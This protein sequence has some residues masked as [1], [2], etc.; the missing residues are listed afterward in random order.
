MTGSNYVIKP[1]QSRFTWT[2]GDSHAKDLTV[3]HGNKRGSELS[4]KLVFYKQNKFLNAGGNCSVNKIKHTKLRGGFLC[5]HRGK[6][7][8]KLWITLQG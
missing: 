3:Y 7:Q 1:W 4:F 8:G 6:N 2:S 5:S